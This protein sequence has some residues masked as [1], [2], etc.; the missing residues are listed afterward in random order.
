MAP[1]AKARKLSFK[2][3]RELDALPGV[4]AALEAEHKAIHEALADGSLYASDNTRAV[5]MSE[6]SAKI[7]DELM[8][9]L[10]RWEALGG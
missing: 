7:D 9:A 5:Q 10:E 4:I 8:Q 3:Q 2:E 6:R 1:A